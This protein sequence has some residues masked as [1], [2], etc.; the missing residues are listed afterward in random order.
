MNENFVYLDFEFNRVSDPFVNLVCCSYQIND[1]NPVSVWLGKD[2][3]SQ[4]SL[5]SFFTGLKDTHT[6]VCYSSAE[7]RSFMSL[8]L[9]PH[10]FK[11]IDLFSEWRQCTHNNNECEYGTIFVNGLKMRSVA[12][13]YDARLNKGKN[14]TRVGAGYADCVGLLFEEYI[15]TKH[16]KDMRD[17]IISDPLDFTEE[18]KTQIMEYCESDIVW[19]PKILDSLTTKLSKYIRR[20]KEHIRKIQTYRGKYSCSLAKMENVGFPI[21]QNY[22]HHLRRNYESARIKL[23][24]DLNENFYPFYER[25]K[26]KKIELLGD[27]V[28]R[29]DAFESFIESKGLI[30]KWERSE[31]SKKLKTDEDTLEKFD[32]IKE[33]HAYRQCKKL[34]K[35]LA[36]LRPVD[37]KEDD[38]FNAIGSDGR[39]RCYFG[40]YGT[41]TGRNAPPAKKFIF[42]M[43]AWLR[44]LVHPEEGKCLVAIDYAS[45]EFAIAALMSGDK[46]MIEAYRSMDPYA[47]FA[48][49]AG[50][51]PTSANLA[52]V[53]DPNKAPEYQVP[54]YKIYSGKRTLFKSTILGLQY[55]LGYRNLATKLTTDTGRLVSESEAFELLKLHKKTFPVY[56]DWLDKISEEYDVKRFLSLWDGWSLLRDNDNSL[57]VRNFPVQGTGAAIMRRA[58]ILAHEKGINVVATLHDAL[59]AIYDEKDSDTPKIL[60]GCMDQAVKDVLG[61]ELK[62]RQ[63][64]D[65]HRHGEIWIEPKGKRYYKI[66]KQYL[67]PM[68]TEEDEK[69]KLL[70]TIFS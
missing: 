27:Y 47:Y 53:K 37:N 46:N 40:P 55:G 24:E 54:T 64:V 10:D 42:A 29:Y 65:I 34:I 49:K 21:K 63:D 33:I 3:L 35:Q 9:D 66:L 36:W 31:K 11:W 23:I 48:Q 41:Q 43:S 50:A 26:P 30:D 59:Y 13:K 28:E 69:E 62:I 18:E 8:H 7:P 68:L 20:S 52:W 58:V 14:N 4:L 2:N 1:E 6:F 38:I 57:S 5:A 45:Q 70:E 17:L 56:W 51:I 32:G 60:S 25:K 16:K 19:L 22:I 39:L 15:D 44:C 61:S 12:P 67:D